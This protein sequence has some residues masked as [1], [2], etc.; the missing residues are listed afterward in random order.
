MFSISCR[1][2]FS[3]ALFLLLAARLSPKRIYCERFPLAISQSVFCLSF[4]ITLKD[5]QVTR[6]RGVTTC[7]VCMWLRVPKLLERIIQTSAYIYILYIQMHII[8]TYHIYDIT[9]D[10]IYVNSI[11]WEIKWKY[12]INSY[13]TLVRWISLWTLSRQIWLAPLTL[14]TLSIHDIFFSN[15]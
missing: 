15:K 7:S 11:H 12:H 2:L 3:P 8:Y 10:S 9:C 5:I 1:C 4:L 13:N 6:S 14:L